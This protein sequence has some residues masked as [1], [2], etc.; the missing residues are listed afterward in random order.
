MSKAKVLMICLMCMLVQGVIAQSRVISGT[1][2][3][4]MGPV[5]FANVTER[6]KDN[7][8][9]SAVQT[10]MMGNFSLEIKNP[11]N[12][13]VISYVGNKTIEKI[14]GDQSFFTIMMEPESNALTEV[15]VQGTRTNSGGLSIPEREMT[16]A[17][18]TF[19]LAEVEGMAFTSAD[20]ALQGEIAGLDIVAN[21]GN[22]GSGT[23]MRLRGVTTING[24][25]NPLIVVDDIIKVN[26]RGSAAIIYICAHFAI[27]ACTGT[28]S[29]LHADVSTIQQ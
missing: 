10:D 20:E 28:K 4:P 5:M 29:L 13:L 14:I 25:A 19:N 2:E 8:I 22:L 15:V 6:D 17:S 24:D 1:I 12:R 26:L 11:K 3:D 27:Y 9:V 16:V 7:R 23:Q 21:S 18:Q